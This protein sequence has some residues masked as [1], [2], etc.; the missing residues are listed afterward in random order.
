MTDAQQYF[1]DAGS[2]PLGDL[3]AAIGRGVAEAQAALDAGALAQTLALYDQGDNLQRT[4]RELGYRP[5]FYTIP[6][7]EGELKLSISVSIQE[8]PTG[9]VATSSPRPATSPP[10]TSEISSRPATPTL[11]SVSPDRARPRVYA[12]PVDG[13]YQ[14]SFSFTS[15]VSATVKFKIV[16][17]PPSTEAE[18]ARPVPNFIGMSYQSALAL[19][20]ALDLELTGDWD[21]TPVDDAVI[22]SQEPGSGVLVRAG[23]AVTIAISTK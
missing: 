9:A 8:T 4:L 1:Q 16:A 20:E 17:V 2:V 13:R 22:E 23:M 14:N 3:I 19:A 11:D 5:T 18:A 15:Q 7:T 12:T 6:E 21:E 10:P